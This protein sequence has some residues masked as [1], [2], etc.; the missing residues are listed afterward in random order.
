MNCAR[1]SVLGILVVTLMLPNTMRARDGQSVKE[2][3]IENVRRRALERHDRDVDQVRELRRFR[4]SPPRVS[5]RCSGGGVAIFDIETRYS[6]EPWR[7][8]RVDNPRMGWGGPE[9][10]T[11]TGRYD[12]FLNESE[13]VA[14]GCFVPLHL[15]Q[16]SAPTPAPIPVYGTTG[17]G[18]SDW[19]VTHG[20][21]GGGGW[22]PY[23]LP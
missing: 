21:T 18:G 12:L 3:I 16:T 6:H 1:S 4:A 8:F 7:L 11:V 2:T 20:S 13:S 15:R 17:A 19:P 14:L 9:R 23:G 5:W 22:A 10:G